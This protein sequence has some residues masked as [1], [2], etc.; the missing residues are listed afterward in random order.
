MHTDGYILPTKNAP[1]LIR[2]IKEF[3]LNARVLGEG[4]TYVFGMGNYKVG[5]KISKLFNPENVSKPVSS[6][7]EVNRRWLQKSVQK[8]ATNRVAEHL[9]NTWNSD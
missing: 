2:A 3:G 7:R 8:I 6:I 5:D 4:E 9:Y 1:I